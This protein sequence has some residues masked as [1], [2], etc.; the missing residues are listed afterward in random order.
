M[1][2]LVPDI[3]IP[4][5]TFM[6]DERR[7]WLLL[8]TDVKANSLELMGKLAALPGVREVH[9]TEGEWSFV[10]EVSAGEGKLGGIAHRLSRI[11]G[12][13]SAKG[14]VSAFSQRG[15]SGAIGSDRRW[16]K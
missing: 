12:V 14:A 7:L 13:R 2:K 4:T 11:P 3:V 9:M 10:V 6:G 15:G 16:K 5:P 1:Q 8:K